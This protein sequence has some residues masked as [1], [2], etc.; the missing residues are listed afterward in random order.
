MRSRQFSTE[1]VP[2]GRLTWTQIHPRGHQV[3]HHRRTPKGSSPQSTRRTRE[4]PKTLPSRH[5]T[6]RSPPLETLK[7]TSCHPMSL[8]A[9]RCNTHSKR[10]RPSNMLSYGTSLKKDA[11]RPLSRHGHRQMTLSGS[12]PT[13]RSSHC[14]QS[15]WLK[16]P[17]MPGWTTSCHSQTS[18]R[19]THPS[20][21]T[22]RR[23]AGLK[24]TFQPCSNSFGTS[25]ATH[26]S[27]P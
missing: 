22:S 27:S 11:L 17:R 1:S 9:I 6:R 19:L 23:L 12:L 15:L 26:F 16:H 21:S 13:A 24:N 8:P 5:K 20:L 14:T 7:K 4:R 3:L 10:L 18:S 2:G 25:N